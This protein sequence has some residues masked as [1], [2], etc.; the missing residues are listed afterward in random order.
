MG[1]TI[2]TQLIKIAKEVA[3]SKDIIGII[4]P[5]NQASRKLL[6]KQ[7]FIRYFIGSEDGLR[8]EKLILKNIFDGVER[9]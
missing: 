1:T 8:T 3:P 9:R 2:C 6:E 4:D 5:D 7:G